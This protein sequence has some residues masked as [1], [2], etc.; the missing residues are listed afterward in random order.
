MNVFTAAV[1]CYYFMLSTLATVGYGDYAPQS[2]GEKVISIIIMVI[3]VA[4]FSYIINNFNNIMKNYHIKLGYIDKI[5]EL[6]EWMLSL[7]IF[8][9]FLC[10]NLLF[11]FYLIDKKKDRAMES[12]LVKSIYDHYNYFYGRYKLLTLSK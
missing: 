4:F 6:E 3:G 10:I 7:S 12:Q 2:P 8:I 11:I 5:P 1:T 9:I